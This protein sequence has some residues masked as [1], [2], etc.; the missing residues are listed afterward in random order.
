MSSQ[1][2]KDYQ[3]RLATISARTAG[4]NRYGTVNPLIGINMGSEYDPS[5]LVGTHEPTGPMDHL[6]DFGGS[7]LDIL[8]RPGYAAGG[9]LNTILAPAFTGKSTGE[10]P[11]NAAW[12]GFTGNR[13]EFFH[14]AQTLDPS[15][16]NDSTAE[17]V[18]HWITDFLAAVFSDPITY[19]PGG[20]F[21]KGAKAL[22]DLTGVTKV[23]NKVKDF[24]EAHPNVNIK[25]VSPENAKVDQASLDAFDKIWDA[26]RAATENPQQA[27]IFSGATSHPWAATSATGETTLI[28]DLINSAAKQGATPPTTGFR[29]SPTGDVSNFNRDPIAALEG[30]PLTN[31][32]NAAPVGKTS[33]VDELLNTNADQ[34]KKAGFLDNPAS[35]DFA[36]RLK[37]DGRARVQGADKNNIELGAAMLLR[38]TM[39]DVL[40]GLRGKYFTKDAL[41]NPWKD[42]LV[43][44]AVKVPPRPSLL[45]EAITKPQATLKEIASDVTDNAMSA[46]ES[47]RL[48]AVKRHYIDNPQTIKLKGDSLGKGAEISK[49]RK[50]KNRDIYDPSTKKWYQN[51]EEFDFNQWAKEQGILTD[52]GFAKWAKTADDGETTISRRVAVHPLDENSQL[53]RNSSN[54]AAA[55]KSGNAMIPVEQYARMLME[56]PKAFME[57]VQIRKQGRGVPFNEYAASRQTKWAQRDAIKSGE[58]RTMEVPPSKEE[59]AAYEEKLRQQEQARLNYELAVKEAEAF[60]DEIKRVPPTKE[61][62]LAWLAAHTEDIPPADLKKLAAAMSKNDE[63]GFLRTVDK[64]ME[65]EKRLDLT[66]LDELET[67]VKNGQINPAELAK[68][69]DSLGAKS[70]PDAKRRLASIE[71]R[72]EDLRNKVSADRNF[73]DNLPP[74][75]RKNAQD[76]NKAMRNSTK[77]VVPLPTPSLKAADLRNIRLKRD[78]Y[79]R[80]RFMMKDYEQAISSVVDPET[81]KLLTPEQIN[82][83][84][85]NLTKILDSEWGT[86]SNWKYRTG[87][88][89]KA[90][91]AVPY[92]GGKRRWLYE[93]NIRSQ[94]TFWK[95]VVSDAQRLATEKGLRGIAASKYKRDT[96]LP[97]IMAHEDLLRAYGIFP[98]VS[99]G[100]K[101]L[102]LSFGDIIT[103]MG[104]NAQL[105]YVFNYGTQVTHEQLFDIA[106]LA[107]KY[108]DNVTEESMKS[109]RAEV[110][111]VI[112]NG[113]PWKEADKSSRSAVGWAQRA[114]FNAGK[115]N[116]EKGLAKHKVENFADLPRGEQMR[117]ANAADAIYGKEINRVLDEIATPEFIQNISDRLVKNSLQA[118]IQRGQFVK[119]FS[120]ETLQKFVADT[121]KV[122]TGD[123]LFNLVENARKGIL[124][125]VKKESD[126][127]PP[128]GS[129][130]EVEDIV[131][132]GTANFGTDLAMRTTKGY[133]EAKTAGANFDNTYKN[134]ESVDGFVKDTILDDPAL[135]NFV[136]I[137]DLSDGIHLGLT[138]RFVFQTFPHLQQG[139]LRNL[140]LNSQNVARLRSE[141]YSKALSRF[142]MKYGKEAGVQAFNDLKNGL[143]ATTSPAHQEMARLIGEIFDVMKTGFGPFSRT[144]LNP[145]HINANLRHFKVDKYF[146]LRGASITDAYNSWRH[147]GEVKDPLNLLSRYHA[148][149]QKTLLE[150]DFGARVS[151]LFGSKT[152]QVDKY[153][154]AYERV[155]ATRGGSRMAHLIDKRLY[156]P[157]DVIEN[158][159]YMDRALAELAKP[160]SNNPFLK[161]FDFVTHKLKTALTIY[162]PGHHMRN[163]YGDIWLSA[164]DGVYNPKYYRNAWD[165]MMSR[166]NFYNEELKHTNEM[167]TDFTGANG[168]AV[169]VTVNGKRRHL[170]NDDV[171]RLFFRNGGLPGYSTIEDLGV[172]TTM[173]MTEKITGKVSIKEPLGGRGHRVV[174]GV[175]EFR[176]HY[177]RMAH[178]LALLD[179]GKNITGKKLAGESEQQFINR[180]L[181]DFA[182]T[183][184]ARVRK[185]HPDGSDLT[186]F[187]RNVAKRGILFYAWIRKAVPLIIESFFTNPGRMLYFPKAMYTLAESNGIDLNGFNDPFPVDQLFPAWMGGTQGPIAGN[188]V[189][190]YLGAKMGIPEMD[191]L[192]QYLANPGEVFQTLGSASHPAARIPIEMFFGKTSQ[193]IPINDTGKY[194]LGQVPFGNLIN[195]TVGGITGDAP[196]GDPSKSDTGYDP[197]G[198]RDPA[199]LA[200]INTMTGLGLIDMSKPSYIKSGEFD[201]KYGRTG[202]R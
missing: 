157:A 70:I 182:Q 174:V 110:Q 161:I 166:K 39:S 159:R 45:D 84:G 138:A 55:R 153:G 80:Q 185:F 193:G 54:P 28:D 82:L 103:S 179:R 23:T 64:L 85:E 13:P 148:A 59:I 6:K 173:N 114:K 158:M 17:N 134:A 167:L 104:E 93:F 121:S 41:K 118:G 81:F 128:P 97:V 57:N 38:S 71:K 24:A 25:G 116:L 43:K 105:R 125:V 53:Y 178:F 191:I 87:R 186:S 101:G 195:T 163:M 63:K 120:D 123:E 50:F 142:E 2:Y 108:A 130:S 165:V 22:G 196:I 95:G 133:E 65:S 9:F 135:K 115:K 189:E 100:G 129:V 143:P 112:E 68:V 91:T 147:W 154:K 92:D 66:T 98:S 199:V 198:I 170:S 145:K 194:L 169:T 99:P 40:A 90:E 79:D 86:P 27:D 113:I 33:I 30:R 69:L 200:W 150:R 10:N 144:G 149:M 72:I 19:I 51:G 62:K 88:G 4:A 152:P 3:D 15:Q 106:E 162:R 107:L 8:S 58:K 94:Y 171:F 18:G 56:K 7:V 36:E 102:P 168:V 197:G 136:E 177:V 139:K 48:N 47:A 132:A 76:L 32:D 74:K 60:P 77:Q 126:I 75:I 16:P 140:L 183:A 180:L 11:F 184:A 188:S 1:W 119:K 192:D 175:S 29:P 26:K 181:D 187:E 73:Y 61:E 46:T 151:Y 122:T 202:A 137:N 146:E 190:G 34:L 5:A 96:T 160:A 20:A 111:N 176:D 31:F 67:A 37:K 21:I 117:I 44:S 131:E 127:V 49:S 78:S 89:A 83:L 12:E 52:E 14:P 35:I 156:Y 172:G 164:M 201:V 42:E 155:T 141:M 124:G 109:F